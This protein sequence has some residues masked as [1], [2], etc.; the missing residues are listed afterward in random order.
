MRALLVLLLLIPAIASAQVYK[1]KGKSGETVYSQAPCTA[2]AQQ[3]VLR[4]GQLA[5]SNRRV[6]RQCLDEAS[7][8]IYAGANDRNASL[9]HQIAQLAAE[10]NH[11]ARIAQLR[12]SI[13]A[14]NTQAN[15]A[16]TQARAGCLRD[17]VSE[18]VPADAPPA[19]EGGQADT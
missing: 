2:G 10:G 12:Q 1:C 18:P 19:R 7:A 14:E 9:Q 16:L 3:H 13:V 5:G 15:R 4:D 11:T 8:R 6:D 17:V